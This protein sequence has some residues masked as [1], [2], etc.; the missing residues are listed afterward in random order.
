MEAS[1]RIREQIAPQLVA[2]L[3]Q[4]IAQMQLR[5]GDVLSEK[6]SS[7]RNRQSEIRTSLVTLHNASFGAR[8]TR[9]VSPSKLLSH[10]TTA[11]L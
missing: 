8:L 10:L 7:H 3:R 5:P 11:L 4:G 9:A 1:L 2:A 6:E